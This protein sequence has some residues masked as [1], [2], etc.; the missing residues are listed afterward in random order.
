MWPLACRVPER[1]TKKEP[2]FYKRS[3]IMSD[4]KDLLS[5]ATASVQQPPSGVD[6]KATT[7]TSAEANTLNQ[8]EAKEQAYVAAESAAIAKEHGIDMQYTFMIEQGKHKLTITP[9]DRGVYNY[10]AK[11]SCAWE[12]RFMTTELA[13]MTAKKHVAFASKR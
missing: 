13:E 11:C 3:L 6:V 1:N 10:H 4:L 8:S 9:E 2:N 12:G 5:P 7:N